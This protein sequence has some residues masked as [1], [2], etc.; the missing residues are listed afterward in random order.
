ME[1]NSQKDQEK[2][3]R[4][5]KNEEVLT[6]LWDNMKWNNIHIIGIPEQEEEQGKSNDGKFPEYEER[7]SHTNPGNTES[8]STENQRGPLQDTP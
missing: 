6:E 5:R 4:L 3:K 7:K 1:K 8:L 2:K